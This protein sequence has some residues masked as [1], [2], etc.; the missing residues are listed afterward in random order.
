[1]TALEHPARPREDRETGRV[2]VG[3]AG[4]RVAG[5]AAAPGNDGEGR[6]HQGGD[7]QQGQDEEDTT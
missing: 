6:R 4:R 2:D 7:G 1:M 5:T 3:P